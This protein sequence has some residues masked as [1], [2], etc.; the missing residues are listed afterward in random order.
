VFAPLNWLFHDRRVFVTNGSGDIFLITT[1]PSF[2]GV[3]LTRLI[4]IPNEVTIAAFTGFVFVVA[5]YTSWFATRAGF[6]QGNKQ[7]SHQNVDVR[8]KSTILAL[9]LL[10]FAGGIS[11]GVIGIG[12]EKMLFVY[13]TW[14]DV[15][16]RS[17]GITSIIAVPLPAPDAQVGRHNV[18]SLSPSLPLSLSPAAVLI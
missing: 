17:A 18:L 15:D 3:A 14:H 9:S 16:S 4:T 2:G 12:I 6:S 1:L 7:P 10:S 8:Q 13:L 11:C 5:V